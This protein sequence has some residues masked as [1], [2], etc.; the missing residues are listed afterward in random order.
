MIKIF[1][2]LYTE[3]LSYLFSKR[4]HEHKFPTLWIPGLFFS[5]H[6]KGPK[7]LVK[8][9]R[10]IM[11]SSYLGKLFTAVLNERVLTFA[12]ENNTFAKEQIGFLKGNRTSCSL[13]ILH[14]LIFEQLNSG[15]KLSTCFIDFDRVPRN[16]LIW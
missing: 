9:Y 16:C 15:E 6:K 3:F 13:I 8:N 14:N 12:N 7:S 4:L 11:L 1:G 2:S 10:G 5:V